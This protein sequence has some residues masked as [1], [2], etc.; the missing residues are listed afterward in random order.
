M[1]ECWIGA[2]EDVRNRKKR[3]GPL[4]CKVKRQLKN[5]RMTKKMQAKV[6]E[7]CV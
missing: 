3:A 4:W 6:Y 5:T 2:K 1:L 7:A